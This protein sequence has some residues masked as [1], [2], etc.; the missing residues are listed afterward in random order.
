MEPFP[1]PKS[2][3]T[4]LTPADLDSRSR[5]DGLRL[6][7]LRRT[8]PAGCFQLHPRRSWVA[9]TRSLLLVGACQAVLAALPLSAE[10]LPALTAL[11][12]VLACGFVGL[13]VIGHDCGHRSF[14]TK[15]WVNDA[16]GYLC[17]A[18]LLTGFH[19]WRIAHNHHHTHTQLRGEDP[20]WPEKMVTHGEFHSL[21]AASR[22]RT[23]LGYGSPFGVLLGF[24]SGVL[25]RLCLAGS[26]PQIRLSAPERRAVLLS[27]AAMLLVT[28]AVVAG[29]L[30]LGGPAALLKHYLCPAA[31][32]AVIGSLLTLLH[33]SREDAPVYDRDDW[34]PLRGQVFS[35]FQ[36]RF[37]AVLEWL[38]LDINIHL[39]HHLSPQVPW[40]HLRAAAAA[41]R[42]A[43]PEY[44]QERPFR[45][46]DLRLL[47]SRPLLE[48]DEAAGLYLP[49]GLPRRSG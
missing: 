2:R 43:Y 3:A 38:W 4:Y 11:W 26:Y 20:D 36:V 9:L 19:S 22:P 31:I 5:E 44:Y 15:R 25:R 34:T 24:W 47:W 16:V 40:Y 29:L 49:A 6:A 32:A 48:R 27:N 13:F 28:G 10:W 33:H 18:P 46:R 8:I 1:K 39:P 21:P 12:F 37:P 35:T 14:S 7:A 17:M 30:R 45:W 41:L 42:A 23:L